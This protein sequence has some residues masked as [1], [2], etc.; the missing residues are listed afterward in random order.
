MGARGRLD[1]VD[2]GTREERRVED[3]PTAT[4]ATILT[5][6][7]GLATTAVASAAALA[8]VATGGRS[9]VAAIRGDYGLVARLAPYHELMLFAAGTLLLMALGIVLAPFLSER[10]P[11]GAP[12]RWPGWLALGLAATSIVAALFVG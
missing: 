2:R 7:V 12:V 5:V 9:M 11:R 3:D 1:L 4:R 6:L 8:T 10:S